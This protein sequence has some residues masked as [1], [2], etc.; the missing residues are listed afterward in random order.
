MV[1]ETLSRVQG[2]RDAHDFNKTRAVIGIPSHIKFGELVF[3]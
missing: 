2:P 1:N 3:D